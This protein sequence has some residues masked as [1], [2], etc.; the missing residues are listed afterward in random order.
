[1][2]LILCDL[3][4][5]RRIAV[6]R[7]VNLD[8]FSER[9]CEMRDSCPH[10]TALSRAEWSC[11]DPKRRQFR[12]QCSEAKAVSFFGRSHHQE[13]WLLMEDGDLLIINV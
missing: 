12:L 8:A 6:Q 9:D 13:P 10:I 4:I 2:Q 3:K 7:S 5:T 1:M 11:L